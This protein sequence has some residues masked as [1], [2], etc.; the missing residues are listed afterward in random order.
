[1]HAALWMFV[2]TLIL[3]PIANAQ[4]TLSD[5][6]S[7]GQPSAS[8]HVRRPSAEQL[9]TSQIDMAF[10][11]AMTRFVASQDKINGSPYSAT[12]KVVQDQ[13]LVDGTLIH[14]TKEFSLFRDVEGR[15]RSEYT[16]KP[17]SSD[18]PVHV[19]V[20]Q[21]P[22]DGVRLV[23]SVSGSLP[24]R[25]AIRER[26]PQLSSFQK[27]ADVPAS[28]P[29]PLPQTSGGISHAVTLPSA[30][31]S[32]ASNVRTE[33][34]PSDTIAGVYVEGTRTTEV[35]TA[36]GVGNEHEFT[37]VS[38]TWTSPDL[39]ITVRLVTDD[40]RTGR[41]TIE[42]TAVNRSE[43]DPELFKIPEGYT[44]VDRSSPFDRSH[45]A[46]EPEQAPQ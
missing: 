42:L 25:A 35:V 2:G 14:Q 37:I 8:N 15:L 38:E 7:N 4:V 10:I 9:R 13:I 23:W 44:V 12:G 24:P 33:A 5:N 17:G 20:V 31:Y 40:P 29:S 34:L 18:A 43:P 45:P 46:S 3:S 16:M 1:M 11:M 6:P 39:K 36:G 32:D 21:D 22:V 27:P 28:G 41:V 30:G 19:V 26:L